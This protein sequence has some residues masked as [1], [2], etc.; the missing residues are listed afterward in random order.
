M[1]D[2]MIRSVELQVVTCCQCGCL[3]A[4]TGEYIATRRR[5]KSGFHCPNGHIQYY[6]E[7][8]ADRLRKQLAQTTQRLDEI[9]THL[10]RERESHH[11]TERSLSAAKG[12]VTKLKN[13]ISA[14]TCPC[15]HRH[16][17][18]LAAHMFA[19]HP[20]FRHDDAQPEIETK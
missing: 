20:K 16:F 4:M 19:E 3:F 13:R 17:S 15:C 14:G 5:D 1:L 18:E 6:T 12:R 7:T 2:T 11:A 10:T 9:Q 8:E